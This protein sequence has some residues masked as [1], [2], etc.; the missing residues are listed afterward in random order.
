M[1]MEPK[2]ANPISKMEGTRLPIL[3][4]HFET[5]YLFLVSKNDDEKNVAS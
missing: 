3:L 2:Q 5:V 4:G 1:A